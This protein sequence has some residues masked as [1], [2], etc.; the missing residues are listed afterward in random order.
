[1]PVAAVTA[2][3]VYHRRAGHLDRAIRGIRAQSL[4]AEV[5]VVCN[6]GQGMPKSCEEKADVVIA[7]SRN[8]GSAVRFP[9]MGLVRSR[10]I[11]TQDDDWEIRD[12][13]LFGQ[14]V[15]WYS[16][17]PNRETIYW[18]TRGGK[19]LTESRGYAKSG[20]NVQQGPAPACNTGYSFLPTS[21]VANRLPL[22]ALH[23]ERSL[24]DEQ[25]MRYADDIWVSAHIQG[26]VH[27][28]IVAGVHETREEEAG[29]CFDPDH[30]PTR[31]AACRRLL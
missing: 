7:C 6:E 26:Y 29:L 25:E 30:Y 13:D 9:I 5:W 18:L 12:P 4:E 28:A 2:L 31:D 14:L 10:W 11:W 21:L 17:E 22:N 16:E 15:D 27:P 8:F 19:T 20:N 3:I 1:M 24:K 23:C